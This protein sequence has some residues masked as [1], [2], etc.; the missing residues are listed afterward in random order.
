MSQ[1]IDSHEAALQA[2]YDASAY[3]QRMHAPELNSR[4]EGVI[5]WV[6]EAKAAA[7]AFEEGN[8]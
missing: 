2:L 4:I 6:V 8:D 3:L 7:D 1:P 5:K